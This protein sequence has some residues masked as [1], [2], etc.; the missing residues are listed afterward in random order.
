M[1]A[2]AGIGKAPTGVSGLDAI[3]HGGLPRERATLL[4]GGPGSGKT[5]LSLKFLVHGAET[6]GEPAIFV[7]FEESAE[8]I[9]ANAASFGWNLPRLQRRHLFFLDA[10]PSTEIVHD[11]SFDL[12]GLLAGLGAKARAMGARR[13]VF[14]AIDVVLDLLSEPGAA[15][16]ELQRLH[17]WQVRHDLSAVLTAKSPGGDAEQPLDGH[18]RMMQFL[19]DAVVTLNHRVESGVSQRSLR[20]LK[21]RGSSF[22]E[23]EAPFAIVTD[24]LEVAGPWSSAPARASTER[25]SSGVE[26][27]DAMLGGGY[28]RNAAV[29]VTGA[30][31]TAKTTLCG[32]FIAAALARGERSLYVSF[33]SEAGELVRNLA[34]VGIKL[35][36]H[37]K[38]GMLRILA[39]RATEGNAENHLLQ[40]RRAAREH[41]ARCVV[42][43]PV[44]AL[45]KR[46]NASTGHGVAERLTRWAKSDGITLACASLLADDRIAAE[47]T[48]MDISTIADTWIHLT[49]QVKAGERNRGLTI[50]KSRGTPH[51]NQVRELLLGASGVSL[52]NVYAAG[53]EVLM[54]TLRWEREEAMR[55]EERRQ[56]DQA[57]RQVRELEEAEAELVARGRA[58]ER[59]LAARREE[60]RRL[61]EKETGR[62]RA[63]AAHEESVRA[64]R[65]DGRSRQSKRRE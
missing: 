20:V 34:S 6:F 14:D 47:S 42:V 24:G 64:R 63:G 11:G 17:E 57:R 36:R 25:V 40:I 53:G 10:R 8:R 23:N 9:V 48:P 27:L 37:R 56:R 4:V 3:L 52:A 39:P 12:H 45:G 49:Y 55:A 13:I 21:Y 51:S 43:D 26:Q 30:P 54:G 50:V 60:R 7:A 1:R 5:L 33:D 16:R 46:G 31:G 38:E 35:A 65:R 61:G 15:R 59:E 19:V 22:H 18:A 28:Y 32:A 58:I 62:R 41:G 2:T 29:L 44:S